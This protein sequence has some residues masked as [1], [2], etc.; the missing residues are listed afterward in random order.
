[1]L[2]GDYAGRIRVGK[3]NAQ[4]NMQTAVGQQIRG[5]PTVILYKGGE[6]VER[7]SGVQPKEKL[8]EAID[9]H[10]G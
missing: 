5:V 9:Q 7:F 10:L 3:M 2:A 1:E 8:A 6:V 4:E